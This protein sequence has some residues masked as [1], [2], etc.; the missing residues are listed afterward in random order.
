MKNAESIMAAVFNCCL[1]E[2]NNLFTETLDYP[3]SK[4]KLRDFIISSQRLLS[5]M[6][7][8]KLCKDSTNST[9]SP[10]NT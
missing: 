8:D 5:N 7:P 1:V 6:R 4:R 3:F 9:L 10:A 2:K